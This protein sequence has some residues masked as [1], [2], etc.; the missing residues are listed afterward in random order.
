MT[1][2]IQAAPAFCN[3]GTGHQCD[4]SPFIVRQRQ[5]NTVSTGEGT[6]TSKSSL[7]NIRPIENGA[8]CEVPLAKLNLQN[9][10]INQT[11]NNGTID[12]K[13]L[14]IPTQITHTHEQTEPGKPETLRA[15]IAKEKV[16]TEAV[17]V[18]RT[19][20]NQFII[21]DGHHRFEV[22]KLEGYPYVPA[23]EIPYL[24]STESAPGVPDV[25]QVNPWNGDE[26]A[27]TTS[28]NPQQKNIRVTKETV[29]DVGL[30]EFNFERKSTRHEICFRLPK[31]SIP[32]EAL[33]DLRTAFENKPK[34]QILSE[35]HLKT[36]TT[37]L[38]N[39]YVSFWTAS[40]P[41]PAR[42]NIQIASEDI[43]QA[44]QSFFPTK[45]RVDLGNIA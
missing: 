10:A 27:A 4:N 8:V 44:C 19:P 17:A 16:W 28:E 21:L 11:N 20:E 34:N 41:S 43:R 45:D 3:P 29:L 32:V 33:K 7:Q 30:S 12:L 15:S 39:E 37:P 38:I 25:I 31:I 18:A 5:T 42:K 35:I 36:I 14:L 22:C 13:L 26:F 6:L 2:R 1:A 40:E 23:F 24:A 9:E